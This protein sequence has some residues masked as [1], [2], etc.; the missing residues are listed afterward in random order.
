MKKKTKKFIINLLGITGMVLFLGGLG[1]LV[2][3]ND[4]IVETEYD[5]HNERTTLIIR[6]HTKTGEKDY[7]Y[8]VT[9]G[10]GSTNP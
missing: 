4:P 3:F 9:D 2:I 8:G 5:T 7:I 1:Y 10:V 6:E